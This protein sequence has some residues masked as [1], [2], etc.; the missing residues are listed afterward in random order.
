MNIKNYPKKLDSK[1]TCLRITVPENLDLA[2]E[3]LIRKVL[4][5]Q[6]KTD[7]IYEFSATYFENLLRI[8]DQAGE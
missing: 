3:G 4:R 5:E 7:E 6:P 8:R 2:L 1:T